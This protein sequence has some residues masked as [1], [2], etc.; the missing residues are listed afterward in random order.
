M[1]RSCRQVC[2][3]GAK[4]CF[5]MPLREFVNKYQSQI[6]LAGIQM[7]WNNKVQDCLER[8]QKER[9]TELERKKKDV[10]NLMAELT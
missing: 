4:D 10:N 9:V 3:S 1:Q 8:G 2:S 6:A 7:L 5:G